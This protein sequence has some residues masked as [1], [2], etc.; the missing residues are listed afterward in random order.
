M[1]KGLSNFEAVRQEVAD[2]AESVTADLRAPESHSLA[3]DLWCFICGES[4]AAGKARMLCDCGMPLEQ[5]YSMGSTALR[6]PEPGS[7]AG[8]WSFA[9]MLPGIAVADRVSLGEGGTPLLR[10]LKLSER[11]DVE[12]WLKDEGQNPT[13]SFKSRG[14][15]VGVSCLRQL[16]WRHVALDTIGNGGAAW[17]AYGARAGV[18]VTVGLPAEPKLSELAESEPRAY[19]AE[20]RW[21]ETT[22]AR[23]AP[24]AVDA[25]TLNVGALCE[26]YRLEGDKT[27]LYE[28]VG[29]LGG[30]L[31]DHVIWPTGGGVGLVGLAKA[32]EELLA[33]GW[34]APSHSMTITAA[35]HSLGGPVSAALRD[36]LATVPDATS[37][38]MAPGVW[39][40][41][42]FAGEYI[43]AR[44]RG[45]G[46]AYGATAG[47]AEIRRAMLHAARAEGILLSPEGGLS[48]AVIENLIADGHIH[49]GE[50]VV[51]VNTASGLRY[52]D[53]WSSEREV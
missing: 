15:S 9:E 8:V 31:P 1:S 23:Q 48:V 42:T 52:Q 24:L 35:Q 51:C 17:A 11:L 13:G 28:I 47:D 29:Q 14:A 30:R 53:L 41:H 34:V 44:I 3:V 32:K 37:A 25:A 7:V 43:L 4:Y 40:D 49:R 10:L 5:R 21:S 33:L 16:G 22:G 45:A 12:V 18:L 6:S 2:E 38:G 27:I 39:A 36:N 20:V 19:G 50:T 26:P 46:D